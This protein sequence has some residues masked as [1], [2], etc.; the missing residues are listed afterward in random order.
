MSPHCVVG[1]GR[2]FMLTILLLS[3]Q[4]PLGFTCMHSSPWDDQSRNCPNLF[5]LLQTIASLV[6]D[7]PATAPLHISACPRPHATTCRCPLHLVAMV[8]PP[9]CAACER[10]T[11]HDRIVTFLQSNV[12][13]ARW[14]RCA[15][16]FRQVVYNPCPLHIATSY[17]Q[18][19][20]ACMQTQCHNYP[21]I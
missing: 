19:M 4:A 1:L 8:V 16:L 20:T 21:P 10:P 14:T 6:S 5:G 12:F 3:V 15:M 2:P 11:T 18:T 13:D 7:L 17:L 9:W